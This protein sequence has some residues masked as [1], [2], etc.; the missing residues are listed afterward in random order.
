[1]CHRPRSVR[2]SSHRTHFAILGQPWTSISSQTQEPI[3][4]SFIQPGEVHGTICSSC[5]ENFGRYERENVESL[6]VWINLYWP[7]YSRTSPKKTK[8]RFFSPT[9]LFPAGTHSGSA[10]LDQHN[11]SPPR[12]LLGLVT[13]SRGL[14]VHSESNGEPAYRKRDG[15]EQKA[16]KGLT[17]Q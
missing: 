15:S 14:Q 13:G 1:M 11:K 12:N 2:K 16:S 3:P 9:Y 17:Q 5:Q 10:P 8:K 7:T 4:F 6:E